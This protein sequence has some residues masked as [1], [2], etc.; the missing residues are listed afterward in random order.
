MRAMCDMQFVLIKLMLLKKSKSLNYALYDTPPLFINMSK[1]LRVLANS[2][3]YSKHLVGLLRSIDQITISDLVSPHSFLTRSSSLTLLAAIMIFFA[4]SF[5]N[6][7]T[8]CSPI[9]ELAPVTKM[10]FPS[11]LIVSEAR[12]H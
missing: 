8:I 10:V 1:Q 2:V 5:A 12:R 7:L 4:P 11:K 3:A 9:P 6:Y